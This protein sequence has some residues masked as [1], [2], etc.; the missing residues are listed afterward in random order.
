MV[1][2]EG[3][4]VFNDGRRI[5]EHVIEQLSRDF[6]G[7]SFG[8]LDTWSEEREELSSTTGDGFTSILSS[9]FESG[10]WRKLWN[11]GH[12]V[13]GRRGCFLRRFS[14]TFGRA[15][16]WIS[17]D[18]VVVKAFIPSIAGSFARLCRGPLGKS[19]FSRRRFIV[20]D[21]R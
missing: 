10:L 12:L 2:G 7:R 14:A 11:S 3:G 18:D 8:A 15:L 9:N 16:D 13:G 21:K 1:G 19:Y 20:V 17:M 5:Y 6:D 4:A